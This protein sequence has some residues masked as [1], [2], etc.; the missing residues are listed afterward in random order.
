[1][2]SEH[3]S[4]G[5]GSK[6]DTMAIWIAQS[7]GRE[8]RLLDYIEGQGQPLAYYAGKLRRRGWSEAIIQLPQDGARLDHEYGSLY[9]GV[10]RAGLRHLAVIERGRAELRRIKPRSVKTMAAEASI[11]GR[12]HREELS[13]TNCKERQ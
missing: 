12:P 4:G 3:F 13:T 9:G 5:A 2:L 6:P 1:L 11:S 7:V 8:I 10:A